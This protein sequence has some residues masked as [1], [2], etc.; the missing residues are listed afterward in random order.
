MPKTR[1]IKHN[2][3]TKPNYIPERQHP[4]GILNR[5]NQDF[6]EPRAFYSSS[7][8]FLVIEFKIFS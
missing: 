2:N 8:T 1:G 4:E 6:F 3:D 7:S 5:D